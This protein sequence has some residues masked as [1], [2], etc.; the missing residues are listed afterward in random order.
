M[1]SAFL[2]TNVVLYLLSADA[3]KANRAEALLMEGAV[4]SVQV[5]NEV[6]SVCLR[7]LRMPWFEIE[8]LVGTVN[9]HCDVQPLTA[10]SHAQAMRLAQRH[11]LSFH[12]AHVV[13][14]ALLAGASMLYSEDTHNGLA[15][16]GL[17]IRNPFVG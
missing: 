4:V 6:T 16:G 17:Q 7:K 14:S 10:Q 3:V 11:R 8:T 15:I 5:L 1:P 9:A 13:S 12:D 2:D